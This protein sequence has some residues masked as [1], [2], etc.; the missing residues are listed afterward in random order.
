MSSAS[1]TH[2]VS[3]CDD[4]ERRH[5]ELVAVLLRIAVALEASAP[6]QD[7]REALRQHEIARNMR[8]ATEASAAGETEPGPQAHSKKKD[9]T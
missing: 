7:P 8:L 4:D 6:P 3:S 1:S 5:V 9:R 2:A